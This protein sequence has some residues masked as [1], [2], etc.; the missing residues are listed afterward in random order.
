MS[1]TEL[2]DGAGNTVARLK[3][4]PGWQVWDDD[5]IL[6]STPRWKEQRAILE[7]F[8]MDCGINKSIDEV[9]VYFD[10]NYDEAMWGYIT[11]AVKNPGVKMFNAAT[12]FVE[13]SPLQTDYEVEYRF[14]EVE[15][16]GMRVEVMRLVAGESPLH[17]YFGRNCLDIHYSF[18]VAASDYSLIVDRLRDGGAVEVQHCDSTYGTF[19]YWRVPGFHEDIF[20]KPR[21][22][23]RDSAPPVNTEDRGDFGMPTMGSAGRGVV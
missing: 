10:D 6:E 22:N 23:K 4:R 18:K 9:A 16:L 8:M 5:P 3:D 7:N 12:D 13:T 2:K 19:S 21:V 20:L 11:D 1:H 14:L 17:D 15:D